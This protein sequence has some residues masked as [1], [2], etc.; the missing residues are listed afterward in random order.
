MS[1]IWQLSATELAQRIA[2]RQLSSI[3]VVNA[4]LARIEAAN[5]SLNAVVRVLAD[6]ARAAAVLADKRLA[7]GGE[8][9][10]LSQPI[11]FLNLVW[12]DARGLQCGDVQKY[13]R[14]AGVVSDQTVTAF[15][16]PHFQFSGRHR[17]LFPLR[18]QPGVASRHR[19]ACSLQPFGRHRLRRRELSG[20]GGGAGRA[21][22]GAGGDVS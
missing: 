21:T 4:H 18:L 13:V 12:I 16:I 20:D 1:E 17:V 11:A 5:P 6:E 8:A 3:E 9:A 14:A 2:R 19:R 15:G 22:G 7:A 10:A